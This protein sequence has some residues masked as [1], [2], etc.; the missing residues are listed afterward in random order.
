MVAFNFKEKF[1]DDVESGRKFSTIRSSKRCN[2]GDAVQLYTG[3]RTKNCR[4]LRD[5]ICLGVAQI[6][7][8]EHM[9]WAISKCT[10]NI[11]TN[12]RGRPL[13]E[14][15]GFANPMEMA[16]FFRDHYGLPFVGYIHQWKG[17]RDD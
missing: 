6:K 17:E 16:D 7:I 5:D 1:A 4:K 9:P 15:E 12:Y 3:Q 8:T 10:G 14:I 13:Y 2:H 11:V